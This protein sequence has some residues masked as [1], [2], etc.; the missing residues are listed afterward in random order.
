VS[1]WL[2]GVN[3]YLIGMM[4]AGKTTVGTLLA[5]HLHYSFLDTD[6]VIERATQRSIPDLFAQE[7]EAE[8][9]RIETQILAQ[10]AAHKGLV[11]ATGGGI[12][13]QL[14]NW[15]YLQHGIVVWLDVDVETLCQRLEGD[16]T[17]PLLQ[18]EAQS[19]HQRLTDLL[20][21]R[22]SRYAQ[23]DVV[24]QVPPHEATAETAERVLTAVRDRLKPS[25][26]PS[27]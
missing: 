13:T 18:Q 17:R 20:E 19:L 27:A 26:I 23:A 11:V 2:K 4:G 10:V 21:Q 22:R 9:R 6:A 8:F 14:A 7:G 16:R 15:S 25:A 24:L 12:P 3:L 1:D 5:K